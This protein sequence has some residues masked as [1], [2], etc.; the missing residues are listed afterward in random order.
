MNA[1]LI[2]FW[3]F[4]TVVAVATTWAGHVG[5]LEAEKTIRQAIEK[6]LVL[7]AATIERLKQANGMAW[8]PRLVAWGIV[9]AFAGAG[10]AAFGLLLAQQEPESLTPLLAIALL[11]A[12]IGAGLAVG[13]WWLG[14]ALGE[15]RR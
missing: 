3:F 6:G 10:V 9:T 14:K 11:L 13:G 15:T 1:E 4:L 2:S 12:F 8:P 7:D 5:R